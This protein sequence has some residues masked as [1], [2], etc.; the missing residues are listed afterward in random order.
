LVKS[1]CFPLGL[2]L[3]LALAVAGCEDFRRGYEPSVGD[4]VFQSL[5]HNP[6]VDAIE[7]AT[8]SRYSHC[9]IVVQRGARYYV[10]EASGPVK[11]TALDEWLE[12]GRLHQFAVYRF[13]EPYRNRIPGIIE[14]AQLFLGKPYDIHYSFDDVR[15]YCSELI[16][17]AFRAEVGEELGKVRRL[18]D[19][20]WKPYAGTIFQI[21]EGAP[22]LDREMI[23]PKDL[24]ESDKLEKVFSQG[25]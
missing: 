17:K 15:I 3:A 13:R 7:G 22:P 10:L 5:P 6:V 4:L 25:I 9:G 12:R 21:E 23:T 1:H 2:A 18:G 8:H 19:L 16:F 20:D 14:R 24:A 11:E